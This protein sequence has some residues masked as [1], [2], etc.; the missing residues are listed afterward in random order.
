MRRSDLL[1][2]FTG[3][4][5]LQTSSWRLLCVSVVQGISPATSPVNAGPSQDLSQSSVSTMA[6]RDMLAERSVSSDWSPTAAIKG[7]NSAIASAA[8][9]PRSTLTGAGRKSS[10]A[11]APLL[12]TVTPQ[13]ISSKRYDPQYSLAVSNPPV[14]LPGALGRLVVR[15]GDEIH[16]VVKVVILVPPWCH[17]VGCKTLCAVVCDVRQTFHIQ[18]GRVVSDGDPWNQV[19]A[20]L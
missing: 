13:P 15:G 9:R 10:A 11:V 8:C 4:L 7:L 2:L 19:C 14:M 12:S 1:I 5:L 20:A 17:T 6:S 16:G 18:I 3:C